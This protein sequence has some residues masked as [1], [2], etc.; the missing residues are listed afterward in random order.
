[1]TTHILTPTKAA[2]AAGV[3]ALVGV[4]PGFEPEGELGAVVRDA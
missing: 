1:M 3:G 4:D 2:P